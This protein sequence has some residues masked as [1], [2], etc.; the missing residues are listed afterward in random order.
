MF[1]SFETNWRQNIETQ[2]RGKYENEKRRR[3]KMDVCGEQ[4]RA[5]LLVSMWKEVRGGLMSQRVAPES[6]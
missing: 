2:E 1:Y 4:G 3:Q 5:G 6:H